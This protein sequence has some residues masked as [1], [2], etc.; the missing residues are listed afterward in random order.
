[1]HTR[2]ADKMDEDCLE[3]VQKLNDA[4][5][6]LRSVSKSNSA[7][8]PFNVSDEGTGSDILWNIRNNRGDSMKDS[9]EDRDGCIEG[10]SGRDSGRD[11]A[12]WLEKIELVGNQRNGRISYRAGARLTEGRGSENETR[13]KGRGKGRYSGNERERKISYKDEMGFIAG[14]ANENLDS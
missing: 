5:R 7:V 9:D 3:D 10:E 8:M 11:S 12:L 2:T 4:L 14:R 6:G 13:G 1:M